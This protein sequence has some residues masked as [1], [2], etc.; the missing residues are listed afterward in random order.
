MRL[1]RFDDGQVGALRGDEVVDVSHLFPDRQGPFPSTFLV[2]A[3]ARFEELRPRIEAAAA[4]GP[5]RPLAGCRLLPPLVFP[6]KVLA[7]PVN[8]KKHQVEMSAANTIHELGFFLKA[9]SSIIGPGGTIRLP[10]PERRTDHEVELAAVIGKEATRVKAAEALEYVFAYTILV[11]V[12]VRGGEDRSTRKSFDTFTPIGPSLVTRDEIPDPQNLR[13]RL[14][15]NGEPRQ[16]ASTRDMIEG[17]AGLIQHA[18]SIMTLYPGDILSTGTPEGVSP[19]KPG[20]VVT[21]E[22]ERLGRME[23]KVAAGW[24]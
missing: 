8:Y 1:V 21:V 20:D 24:K 2:A 18:S 15:L 12:T 13:M 14:W 22:I 6:T 3:I 11:D 4:G 7:A 17:V 10:F 9:P 19:L 23:L 16:D 5:G